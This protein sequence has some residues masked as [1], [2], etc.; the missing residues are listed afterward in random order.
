MTESR[1]PLLES[2]TGAANNSRENRIPVLLMVVVQSALA[3]SAEGH[4]SWTGS[5]N[6][7]AAR[8]IS[9]ARNMDTL[10]ASTTRRAQA[11]STRKA[12]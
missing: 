1:F 11:S 4:C 3:L 12:S 9:A 6:R 2:L 10:C 8:W 5:E 7:S